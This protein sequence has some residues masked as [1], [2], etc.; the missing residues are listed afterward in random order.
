MKE[1]EKAVVR[2]SICEMEKEEMSQVAVLERES[3]GAT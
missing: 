2:L 1:R 3:L